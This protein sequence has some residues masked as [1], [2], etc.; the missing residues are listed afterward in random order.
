MRAQT[1]LLEVATVGR[2]TISVSPGAT[3]WLIKG[4]VISYKSSDNRK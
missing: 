2:M 3:K 4:A 1:R